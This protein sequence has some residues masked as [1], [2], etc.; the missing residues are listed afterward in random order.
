MINLLMN[1]IRIATKARAV[2]TV[3]S[4]TYNFVRNLRGQHKE[5]QEG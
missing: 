2:L 3:L 1:V 5:K 4:V